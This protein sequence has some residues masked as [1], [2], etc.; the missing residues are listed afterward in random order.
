LINSTREKEIRYRKTKI[1][2]IMI[3]DEEYQDNNI[4][5]LKF[6]EAN[7]NDEFTKQK[8]TTPLEQTETKDKTLVKEMDTP[9][10]I[11]KP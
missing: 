2:A 1:R 6:V 8:L 7:D 3:Q 9:S 5:V 4:K 11:L 10:I